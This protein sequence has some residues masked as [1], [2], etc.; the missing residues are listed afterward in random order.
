MC[1]RDGV[2][3]WEAHWIEPKQEDVREEPPIDLQEMFAGKIP[4]SL[5]PEERLLPPKLLRRDFHIGG[6]PSRAILRMSARGLYKATINGSEVTDAQLTPDYTSYGSFLEWQTFDVT[7]CLH[8]GANTWGIVLADGWWAGRISIKGESC[9]FGKRLA[10]FGQLDVTFSDGSTQTVFTDG[11]FVSSSGKYVYSDIFI[12]EKQDLRLDARGWDSPG[13]DASAW[14]SCRPFSSVTPELAP[15]QGPLVRRMER[16]SAK[17]WWREGDSIVVDFGQVIAGRLRLACHLSRGQ[18]MTICHSEVLDATGKFFCN[19]AGRNKDQVDVFIGRGE[20]E[21][22]EPDF[23]FHGFRYVRISGWTGAFDPSCATA[24]VVRADLHETGRIVTSNERVN[25][26][27]SNIEWSQRGNMVTV[28]T[29]CPQRERAG[30]TCDTQVFAPTATFFMDVREFLG[31]WLRN[32]RADQLADGEI[33]DYSPAPKG[34]RAG[35]DSFGTLSSAGWGDAIVIV[36]W[37]LFQRYGDIRVLEENY[38]A[39]RRWHE[40]SVASAAGD[41]SGDDRYVWDTKF[42]YGDWMFPSYMM[43]CD[44]P[45]PVATSLATKDLVAT[46]YLAH[47]SD[48]LALVARVLDDEGYASEC[49]EYAACVRRAFSARFVTDDGTLTSEFQGCYVLS[50]AFG[51]VPWEMRQGFADHLAHMIEGN[52][53]LLDV[54]FLSIG[55]LLDVLLDWG[56]GDLAERVFFQTQCPSWLYEVDRGATSI[57]ESWAGIQPDG[58][59]GNYSFNHCAFGCV[60]DWI[61]RRVAGLSTRT[62]GFAEFEVAP[63]P[64]SQLD[65]MDLTYESVGGTIRLVWQGTPD[66]G[67][68]SLTVPEGLKAHVLLPGS[69]EEIV[70]GGGSYGFDW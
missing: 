67:N 59:V 6:K 61:V 52:G 8:A 50:L 43:G 20:D 48:L 24:V 33:V 14:E 28:P 37:V 51:L 69:D 54:G 35:L 23:T 40:Y 49:E 16:L 32:V 58:T 39:M 55:Y 44:A 31:R 26:L 70:C 4:A 9:Q 45:G 68:M 22:L 18:E 38:D 11:E 46:A 60:G 1:D 56:H 13:F 15:Q 63:R 7:D 5:P 17:D 41:K 62:P 53:D 3:S 47:Q 25:Q 57:W 12:G 10:A 64:L 29:D 34:I 42:H 2:F 21:V 66:A 65:G 27:L 19:I 36:P 30:W